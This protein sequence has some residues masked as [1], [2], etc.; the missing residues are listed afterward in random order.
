MGLQWRRLYPLRGKSVT[1]DDRSRSPPGT[2]IVPIEKNKIERISGMVTL[3]KVM[4][5]DR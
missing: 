5:R 3:E 1:R 2:E 4:I